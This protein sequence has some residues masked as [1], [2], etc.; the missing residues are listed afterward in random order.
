MDYGVILLGTQLQLTRVEEMADPRD[1]TALPQT[2]LGGKEVWK[3][4][5]NVYGDLT[6][7][8]TQIRLTQ[9]DG[10]EIVG[11]VAYHPSDNYIL[12]FT[13]DVDTLPVNTIDAVD[14][15]VDPTANTTPD[16]VAGKV[17]GTRFLL[18]NAVGSRNTIPG[19]G[20]EVWRGTDG[21]DL[22][23]NANDIIEW[24]GTKW[25]VTFDSSGQSSVQ[26]VS[27]LTSGVQYKWTGS[28]WIK[29]YEGEYKNGQ[30]TLV[31]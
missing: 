15:I 27:N 4:L 25:N 30:W 17:T 2:K 6:N 19:R 31:L 23:A 20:P 16:K 24:D 7:G 8:F 26:Y 10:T 12:L 1:P 5:V 3:D 21:S 18:L 29:S 22:I 28:L 11:T 13:S 9:D 14:S